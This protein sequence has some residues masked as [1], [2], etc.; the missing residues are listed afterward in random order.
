M[1]I[2]GRIL[3]TYALNTAGVTG[4][5]SVGTSILK[6]S[7]VMAMANM[8]SVSVSILSVGTFSSCFCIFLQILGFRE[9]AL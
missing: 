8:P 5:G 3:V 1:N 2:W 9:L 4:A 7:K 6:T